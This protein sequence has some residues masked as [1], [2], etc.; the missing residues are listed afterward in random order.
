VAGT[1]RLPF[2]IN[3][4]GVRVIR[5]AYPLILAFLFSLSGVVHS[6][7][8]APA[9]PLVPA[10][11]QIAARAYLLVDA[12]S[13]K[14][15]VEHN[16]DERLAPAS[17][18]KMM[19]G[20]VLSQQVGDGK[21]KWED[22]AHISHNAWAQNPVFA[23]SSLM[24]V[25]VDTD[26]SLRD[27]YYGVV[28]SSGNDASVAIAEHLAGSEDSFAD[29]MNLHA[30]R[31]GMTNSHFVNSHGLPH[32][33]HYT[34]ARDLAI[35]AKAM[36]FDHPEDYAVYAER[37]FTYNNIRQMNRN[38]LLGE[39]GVDGIKTG[40]TSEAGYCL[41]SSAERDGMR[42]IAVVMGADSRLARKEESRKLL[43]YGSRFFETRK[44]FA[45]GDVVQNAKVWAGAAD[46]AALGVSRDI[47]LTVPRGQFESLEA[48][49]TI[50]SV[51]K[52]PV[53]QGSEHGTL[54]V[55]LGEEELLA[56]PL[57]AVSGVE[58]GSFFRVIWDSLVLFFLKLFGQL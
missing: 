2:V 29:M 32:P 44:L 14:V 1:C 4:P 58:R 46:Q 57:R 53:E 38:E 22:T 8:S 6:Q 12:H 30:E 31:L 26:V 49:S 24:W 37:Y 27:L 20:Y 48:S 56:E 13:G 21:L 41:V 36:I 55:K 40:H 45:A 33:E 39:E 25:E 50:D 47:Y 10:P 11:P 17:L 28:I 5:S 19:T 3:L 7:G 34:T 52:A 18:T 9:A 16:A 51:I 35:L 54:V 15:I 42:L 43:A 23:G